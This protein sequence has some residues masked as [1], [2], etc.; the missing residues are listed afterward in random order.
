MTTKAPIMH[1]NIYLDYDLSTVLKMIM[2]ESLGES[3]AYDPIKKE[4]YVPKNLK[5][6]GSLKIKDRE[7][8][9]ILFSVFEKEIITYIKKNDNNEHNY[10]FDKELLV[11]KYGINDYVPK[12]NDLG[13]INKNG[14]LCEVVYSSLLYLNDSDGGELIL[15]D[16]EFKI[17]K[18]NLI[19]FPAEKIHSV[20]KVKSGIRYAILFRYYRELK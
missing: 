12:H 3:R 8:Y 20:N 18:G 13:N 4:S 1:K 16:E 17:K 10:F 5:N 2:N 6:G 9:K 14:K 19:V 15:A 7:K 11:A